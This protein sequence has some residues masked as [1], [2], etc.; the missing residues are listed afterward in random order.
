M[1]PD[2][3]A[4][5]YHTLPALPVPQVIVSHEQLALESLLRASATLETILGRAH[6]AQANS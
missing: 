6:M 5:S 1:L 2:H 3:E 4:S